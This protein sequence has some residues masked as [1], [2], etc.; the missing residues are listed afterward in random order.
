MVHGIRAS[1]YHSCVVH[2]AN[3]SMKSVGAVR[4]RHSCVAHVAVHEICWLDMRGSV[5][6]APHHRYWV[7]HGFIYLL[8]A[9]DFRFMYKSKE[10][11]GKE[12]LKVFLKVF[13]GC[14]SN[15]EWQLTRRCISTV[16]DLLSRPFRFLWVSRYICMAGVFSHS[17]G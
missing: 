16:S 14:P 3:P 17:S 5:G 10:K 12:G 1:S 13:F 15:Y 4:F 9:W 8:L 2:V 7:W 6:K 11:E